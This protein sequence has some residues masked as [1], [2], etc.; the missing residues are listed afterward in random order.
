MKYYYFLLFWTAV[1]SCQPENECK[2]IDFGTQYLTPQPVSLFPYR[3]GEKLIFKD[4]ADHELL[5]HLYPHQKLVSDFA[6]Y[7]EPLIEG[8]CAGKAVGKFFCQYQHAKFLSDSLRYSLN[9]GYAVSWK[10]IEDKPIFYDYIYFRIEQSSSVGNFSIVISHR[11]DDRGNEDY[12][13]YYPDHKNFSEHIQFN[14]KD[15]EKV[16]SRIDNAGD[17][18]HYNHALGLIAFKP[19]DQPLWVLDRI[20]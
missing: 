2:D 4:T 18:I 6:P 15:F 11:T 19:K 1:Q 14:Q 10:W 5:F 13:K 3:S 12:L 9:C 7:D 16:F 8:E 20:E 17:E